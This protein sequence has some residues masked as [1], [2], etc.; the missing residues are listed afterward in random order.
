M[1]LSPNLSETFEGLGRMPQ[2][3]TP[4][5][6]SPHSL[7]RVPEEEAQQYFTSDDFLK[8]ESLKETKATLRAGYF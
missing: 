3:V 7:A 2:Q 6:H 1:N 4:M 8:I 5:S